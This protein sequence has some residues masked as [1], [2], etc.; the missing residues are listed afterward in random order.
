MTTLRALGYTVED[1]RAITGR[2]TPG[3][4]IELLTDAELGAIRNDILDSRGLDSSLRPVPRPEYCFLEDS[5]VQMW[6]LDPSIKPRPDGS[7]DEELVLSKV[8][9]KRHDQMQAGDLVVSY[10]KQGRL[11]PGRVSRTM[12]NSSTHILDFWGTGT[13]PGHAYH[14][15]DGPLKGEHAPIMDILRRDGALMRSDGTMFR[16]ATNCD[17]GS[18]GDMM[19][20]AS[21]RKQTPDGSW[22]EPKQGKVRFG[23]WIILPDGR[24]MS[25]MEMAA[26]EGWRVSDDGYMVAMMKG[27][28]GA[29]Q[30]QKFLFPYAHGE[31]LPKPEDYILARS[32]VTLE[33]IYLANEWE[34]IGT[35]MP[36]PD[37]L[38]G[39]NP[40]STMNRTK[41]KPNIPP[42][43][44]NRPDA[45]TA[46]NRAQRPAHAPAS[47][48]APSMNRKQR[49]VMEA[50]QRK[51]TKMRK[52][53]AG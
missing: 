39:F 28:D 6:P 13:T 14:C 5:T 45:P 33:D 4:N 43:F 48:S 34:Q 24:H 38:A 36:A 52:K 1:V 41:P 7:Y 46:K 19:I 23:T 15:A 29:L 18:M 21:A 31:E 10:D 42:A 20:H 22:T 27:E 44:A 11:Q 37:S 40:N 12:T 9:Y 50:K 16:A 35:R 3:I 32:A 8:W 53:A 49:K 2:L 25:F 47:P 30:E 17:V 51:A 26:N